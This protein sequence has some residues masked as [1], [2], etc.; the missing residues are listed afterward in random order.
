MDV[1][2]TALLYPFLP[3]SSHVSNSLSELPFHSEET[4]RQLP[5]KIKVPEVADETPQASFTPWSK[6]ELRAVVKEFLNLGCNPKSL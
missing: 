1:T 2:L 5:F 4:I 3:E 6:M